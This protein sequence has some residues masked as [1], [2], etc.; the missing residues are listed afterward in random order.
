MECRRPTTVAGILTILAISA[1]SPLIWG[2]E[3]NRKT[4][5]G[6]SE[7]TFG[8]RYDRL[9][10]STAGNPTGQD[11]NILSELQWKTESRLAR[12]RGQL[13]FKDQLVLKGAIDY[14]W[15]FEG[16]SEDSDYL[17]DNRRD[18][19]SR[20]LARVGHG[21]I[22]GWSIGAGYHWKLCPRFSLT[23]LA[24]FGKQIQHFRATEGRQTIS[25][26]GFP[27]PLGP[28]KGLNSTFES[29]WQGPWWG[30]ESSWRAWGPLFLTAEWQYQN[31]HFRG[32]GNWNLRSDFQ[33]PLSFEH[34]SAGRATAVSLGG[35]Y[36][37]SKRWK[38]LVRYHQL[39]GDVVKGITEIFFRDGEIA[40]TQFNGAHRRTAD[41][42]AGLEIRF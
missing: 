13:N 34:T 16:E 39:R 24:G 15:I 18:P 9:E 28:F 21:R 31:V 3:K 10:W 32:R 23:P 37:F 8:Q 20:S 40:Q 25:D 17:S 6:E 14:A 2:E 26:F 35:Y 42:L 27:V 29:Q 7:L 4:I 36:Q 41:W 5:Q 19:F 33:H 38:G 11:P 30:A 22:R 12:W 1:I